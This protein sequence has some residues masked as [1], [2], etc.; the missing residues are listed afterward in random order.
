MNTAVRRVTIGNRSK[1]RVK[2]ISKSLNLNLTEMY[3]KILKEWLT[4]HSPD[5][6]IKVPDTFIKSSVAFS[7]E[8]WEALRKIAEERNKDG[9]RM[10]AIVL[11]EWLSK[12]P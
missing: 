4:D 8:N 7:D 10:F 5:Y 3:N 2:S 1:K 11:D 9:S 6:E 12:Q